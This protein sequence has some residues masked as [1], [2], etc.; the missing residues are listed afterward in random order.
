MGRMPEVSGPGEVERVGLC[1][2]R[3]RTMGGGLVMTVTMTRDVASPA[4]PTSFSTVDLDEVLQALRQLSAAVQ[5][6]V[7]S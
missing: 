7:P 6:D 2:V 3:F 5:S 1:I 4:K